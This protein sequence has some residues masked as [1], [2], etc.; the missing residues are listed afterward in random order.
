MSGAMAGAVAAT[1]LL[2]AGGAVAATLLLARSSVVD[3]PTTTAPVA[4]N[5]ML[6]PFRARYRSQSSGTGAQGTLS[7]LAHDPGLLAAVRSGSNARVRAYVHS[8][9]RSV[10]YHWHVSR[11][12]ITRGHVTV[13]E[14]GVPFV[15]SGPST[16]LRDA[17]GRAIARLQISMQDVIGYVRLNSRLDHVNT[18]VRGRGPAD[19][20]TSL[21]AALKVKLPR[22]GKVTV[23][24]HRYEVGSF[25][26]TGWRGEP[27]RVW[28]LE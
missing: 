25:S 18:V 7:R 23:A 14:T 12:R 16:T 22:S 15:V 5:S 3:D 11:M 17:R 27:L 21:P 28:I 1:L 24:G 20:R 4:S 9:F 13:I 10:W 19:V 26:E 2:M 6:A 8:R